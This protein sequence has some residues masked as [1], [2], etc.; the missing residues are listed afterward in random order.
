MEPTPNGGPADAL[1]VASLQEFN[2]HDASPA[3]IE[4]ADVEQSAVLDPADVEQ[5][6]TAP[7]APAPRSMRPRVEPATGQTLMPELAQVSRPREP[8]PAREPREKSPAQ[9]SSA[10]KRPSYQYE[11]TSRRRIRRSLRRDTR[12]SR[13]IGAHRRPWVRHAARVAMFVML[14]GLSLLVGIAIA[15][16][17]K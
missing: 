11:H 12:P 2:P 1:D 16:G 5:T 4:P 14:F 17:Q 13:S 9:N 10:M 6:P 15:G 7:P 3:L 8:R